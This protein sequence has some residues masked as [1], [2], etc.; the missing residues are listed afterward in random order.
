MLYS[1]LMRKKLIVAACLGIMPVLLGIYVLSVVWRVS[2]QEQRNYGRSELIPLSFSPPK[3]LDQATK[4][5]FGQR[6]FRFDNPC[7]VQVIVWRQK[8]NGFQHMFGSAL[9]SYELGDAASEKLFCANEFAEFLCDWNGVEPG[10]LLD[11]K[12]D[13]VNNKIGRNIGTECRNLKLSGS[14]VEDFIAKGCVQAVESDPRFIPHYADLRVFSLTESELGC[15]GLP[16]ANLFNVA[17]GL[18]QGH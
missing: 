13:L 2:V 5:S 7:G 1:Q 10:D 15:P 9:A 16:K 17:R 14:D 3:C 12:K 6:T 8:I 18:L 11:R 4:E